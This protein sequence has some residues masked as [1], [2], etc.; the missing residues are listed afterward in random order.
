MVWPLVHRVLQLNNPS[1]CQFT[2]ALLRK[3]PRLVDRDFWECYLPKLDKNLNPTWCLGSLI[4]GYSTDLS[5][6]IGLIW[7]PAVLA[8]LNC[9][10]SGLLLKY[11]HWTLPSTRCDTS[12]SKS[13]DKLL[14]N[15][16]HISLHQFGNALK[17]DL[18]TFVNV[19]SSVQT[20][21]ASL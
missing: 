8:G 11:N 2:K 18:P 20:S 6:L 13:I 15:L 5:V 12:G 16:W 7:V 1:P 9:P 4:I 3:W 21:E 17:L 14:I 10:N 19:G